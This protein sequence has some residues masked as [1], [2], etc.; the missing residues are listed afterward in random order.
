MSDAPNLPEWTEWDD[1][2]KMKVIATWRWW[3]LFDDKGE[4]K[5]IRRFKKKQEIAGKIHHFC[6]EETC[7]LKSSDDSMTKDAR[8]FLS[9][10]WAEF[11]GWKKAQR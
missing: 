3:H 4:P 6:E 9:V 2:I 1:H 8:D 7:N 11:T 5:V 10:A